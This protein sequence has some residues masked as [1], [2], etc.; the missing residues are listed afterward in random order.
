MKLFFYLRRLGTLHDES[1]KQVKK[2]TD[3]WTSESKTSLS[4]FVIP[5]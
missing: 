3:F 4:P 5:R 1:R 2:G